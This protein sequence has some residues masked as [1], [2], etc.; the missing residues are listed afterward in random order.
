MISI[1]RVYS[2][3][4]VS[5]HTN[6]TAN[7]SPRSSRSTSSRTHSTQS[8]P[9]ARTNNSRTSQST[10]AR[11]TTR[12]AAQTNNSASHRG[13]HNSRKAHTTPK[14]RHIL[15]WI[16]IALAALFA[17]GIAVFAFL[18]ATTEVPGPEKM[19]MAQKTTV[20]YADGTTPIG[21]FAQQN[22]EIIDCSALPDYVGNA[23]VASENRTF[24]TDKGIDLKGIGRALFNN[25]TKG[26]RQGGST[27]TQQYAE[28][29]YLGETTTYKGKVKEAILALKIA[30]TQS[31]QEVLCNYMN[32]IYFGRNSYGIQAAAKSYFGVEA[33]DLTLSQAATLAGI[34]PSPNNWDPAV[35]KEMAQK[36]FTRVINIMREDNSIS[37]KD[38]KAAQM[39]DTI[40]YNANN[41]YQG[42]NGYLLQ[43]VRQELIKSKAFTEEDLDTG[44]YSIVTTIDK[45]KQDLM[46]QTASPAIAENGMP[47]GLQVGGIS[48]NPKDG[49]I[50][51][52]YAGEDYITKPYNNVTQATFEVGSTMKPFTLLAAVEQGVSLQTKFNGNSPRTFPG[53][54]QPL[55]NA[56]NAS[57]GPID[58]THAIAYSVNMPFMD[59]QQKIGAQGVADTAHKAGVTGDIST[60]GEA[61]LYTTLGNDGLTLKSMTQGY[62][63]I[64]NQGKKIPL[65]IVAHVYNGNKKELYNSP[66]Q[67]E[68]VFSAQDTGLVVQAMQATIQYGTGRESRTIGLPMA[69]KSGTANDVKAGCFVGFTPSFLSY[70]AIWYPGEDGSAQEIPT[71]GE[72]VN[73][74]MFPEH[75]YATYTRQAL[76]GAEAE[77][78]PK[79]TDTGTIGGKDGT[80]GLGKQQVQK[81]STS[82]QESEKS[83]TTNQYN[84]QQKTPS[85]ESAT[86]EQ[87]SDT[88]NNGSEAGA[89]AGGSGG[90]GDGG[91]SGEAGSSEENSG[92]SDTGASGTAGNANSG[93]N[94]RQG[95]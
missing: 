13:N 69:G 70:F 19:A 94:K 62:Q 58:L 66:T 42:T 64:A 63:T 11:R 32:T 29:Y 91:I 24:W 15:R 71:F 59:I 57:Y 84:T 16:L 77:Q 92:S 27:I 5:Q 28:R 83:N 4:M 17:A 47:Q 81:K 53:L 23:I 20:Y 39:P 67:G 36:R 33:K 87:E 34:I 40:E 1:S 80:W 65:H 55:T 41:V 3:L 75:L 9:R 61:S 73:G 46:Y 79:V 89:S 25:I 93:Q 43:M 54:S 21:T 52:L 95:Q 49:S 56:G 22:R 48:I 86:N 85:D 60:T 50:I 12:R 35:D 37:A 8:E 78:F 88:H 90:N 30:Q 38:A 2:S 44:G 10:G 14:K 76:A 74:M 51:A 6:R 18:Y 68:Q 45:A 26:T 82:S 72:Y 31:K 7:R